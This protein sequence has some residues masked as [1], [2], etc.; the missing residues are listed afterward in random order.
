MLSGLRLQVLKVDKGVMMIKGKKKLNIRCEGELKA[1]NIMTHRSGKVNEG[2]LLALWYQIA[3]TFTGYLSHK[4]HPR[5][6]I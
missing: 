6:P 5:E 4:G 1:Y 2:L 3:L